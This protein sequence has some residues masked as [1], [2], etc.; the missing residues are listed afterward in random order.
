MATGGGDDASR[1]SRATAGSVQR[2]VVI[3]VRHRWSG[4]RRFR[5]SSFVVRRS[6]EV[7]RADPPRPHERPRSSTGPRRW[8]REAAPVAT[9]S[10]R[11]SARPAT[12]STPIRADDR[13]EVCHDVAVTARWARRSCGWRADPVMSPRRPGACWTVCRRQPRTR[14]RGDDGRVRDP[15]SE[16]TTQPRSRSGNREPD[17]S[18]GD[19]HRAGRRLGR[20]RT[21]QRQPR[22]GRGARRASASPPRFRSSWGNQ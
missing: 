22:S 13:R 17:A 1:G 15:H 7:G 6:S 9:S 3:G 4:R 11:R 8:R 10:G 2:V 20:P 12:S 21:A 16:A 18:H 14:S 19:R 5:R